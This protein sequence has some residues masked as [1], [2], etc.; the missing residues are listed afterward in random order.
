[1]T[2]TK[3]L[4]PTRQHVENIRAERFAGNRVLPVEAQ[5]GHFASKLLAELESR[6]NPFDDNKRPVAIAIKEFDNCYVVKFEL[7]ETTTIDELPECLETLVGWTFSDDLQS[8]CIKL[9]KPLDF[10]GFTAE[11]MAGNLS[12]QGVRA[13]QRRR[14]DE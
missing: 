8:A 6:F 14:N 11:L 5:I 12:G 13:E 9:E 10:A 2:K 1:M 4:S 3:K 7:A